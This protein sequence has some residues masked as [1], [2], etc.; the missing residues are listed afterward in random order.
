MTQ[1]AS[2]IKIQ[3][4]PGMNANGEPVT[5]PSQSVDPLT[6]D[7]DDNWGYAVKIEDDI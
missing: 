3:I 6:I 7:E 2:A 5:D 1:D 4:T